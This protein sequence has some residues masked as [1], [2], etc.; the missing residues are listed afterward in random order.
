M[1]VLHADSSPILQMDY[2]IFLFSR[3]YEYRRRGFSDKA[4]VLK[5]VYKTGG[6]VT[7]AG[8][9]MAVAFSGL[10]FSDA[11]V[12]NEYGVVL[13]LS[14][15]FD[16]FVVRTMMVP[17]LVGMLRCANWWPVRMPP[18]L[19]TEADPTDEFEAADEGGPT[20]AP[21]A[22]AAHPTPGLAAEPSE[23]TPLLPGAHDDAVGTINPV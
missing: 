13:C 19:R 8:C 14:V 6:V 15:L 11:W 17:A 22:A 9:V 20:P 4:C 3:I 12:L 18:G 21:A 2:D 23:K 16:T 7:A 10:L 1:L 5:G